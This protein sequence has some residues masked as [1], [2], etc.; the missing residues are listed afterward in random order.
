MLLYYLCTKLEAYDGKKISE[1]KS[2]NPDFK[3]ELPEGTNKLEG[4]LNEMLSLS[5]LDRP[6]S[7]KLIHDF[8]KL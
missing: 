1:I 6:N 3:I 5:P 8:K 4:I 2:K 7:S